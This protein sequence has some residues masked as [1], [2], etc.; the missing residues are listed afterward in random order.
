MIEETGE[1]YS[2]VKLGKRKTLNFSSKAREGV[3]L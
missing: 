2:V 3:W 1:M